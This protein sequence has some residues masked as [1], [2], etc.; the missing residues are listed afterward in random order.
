MSEKKEIG[1]ITHFFPKISVAV[2]ELS[3]NL[4]VGDIISIQGHDNMYE[5]KVD[6]MQVEHESVEKA[7]KGDAVGLKVNKPV[8][9]NDRVY[10]A[11]E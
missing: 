5:Q 11:G 6:S 1:R 7:K 2:I 3:G 9:E 4:K 10:L 8:K